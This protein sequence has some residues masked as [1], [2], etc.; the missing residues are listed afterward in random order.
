MI[1]YCCVSC[2]WFEC[3]C[4]QQVPLMTL[5]GH[6]EGIS[7]A[8]WMDESSI[9]TASW[10]HS[11]R[12]WDLQQATATSIIVRLVVV[13]LRSFGPWTSKLTLT[14]CSV[15]RQMCLRYLKMRYLYKVPLDVSDKFKIGFNVLNITYVRTIVWGNRKQPIYVNFKG[16]SGV[17]FVDD[18]AAKQIWDLLLVW[19]F[20]MTTSYLYFQA[21]PKAFFAVAY[22]PVSKRIVASSADRHVRLYDSRCSGTWSAV[23]S[24]WILSWYSIPGRPYDHILLSP[25]RSISVYERHAA[26]GGSKFDGNLKLALADAMVELLLQN[27]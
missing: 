9:C 12:L 23:K 5:S 8:A 2:W 10:D 4:P 13:A 6:S 14:Y 24:R 1:V 18:V 27:E 20:L 16:R 21:G 17:V 3:S 25:C 22:S 19:I 7:S 15:C 11:I 26:N